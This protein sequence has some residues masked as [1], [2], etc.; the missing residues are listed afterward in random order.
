MAA[1]MGSDRVAKDEG[2]G[3]WVERRLDGRV[4]GENRRGGDQSVATGLWVSRGRR[5]TDSESFEATIDFDRRFC[6]DR[7]QPSKSMM[8][9]WANQ[10]DPVKTAGTATK[11]LAPGDPCSTAFG[12]VGDG[13]RWG[14]AFAC[15]RGGHDLM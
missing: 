8:N 10:P 11:G 14:S 1:G 13:G 9:A 5:A 2:G 15:T 3:G 7:V 12:E 6:S 4:L